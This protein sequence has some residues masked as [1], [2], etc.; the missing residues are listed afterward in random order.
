MT[1][2]RLFIG[3][4]IRLTGMN[5]EDAPAIM[6]WHNDSEFARLIDAAIAHPHLKKSWEKIIEEQADA[7]DHFFFAIRPVDGE[8]CIGLLE[9]D[10]ILWNNGVAWIAVGIGE[11]EHRGKGYAAE[12][13][14]LALD[15]TFDELNLHRVQLT[16]FAYNTPAIKLYERLGF[17]HEGTYREF[18]HR[19]GQRFDMRLYGILR[20]EWEA[21]Y[22]G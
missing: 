3:S 7:K 10:N 17:T 20:H 2:S 19:D 5:P 9:L 12:A 15:Y 22:R 6:K 18:I 21:R 1:L 4:K 13:M 8:S 14:S 16:V 11:P